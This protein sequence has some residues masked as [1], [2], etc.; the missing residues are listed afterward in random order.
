VTA[1]EIITKVDAQLDNKTLSAFVAKQSDWIIQHQEYFQG[2]QTPATI[3]VDG[4]DLP[5][6]LS[7]HPTDRPWTWEDF[8][9]NNVKL[10]V[11]ACSVRIDFH[12]GPD[13]VGFTIYETFKTL[14]GHFWIKAIGNGPGSQTFDWTEFLPKPF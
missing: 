14:D 5:L 8:L 3:P 1:Q 6:D 4:V 13:G 10:T 12:D 11:L 2:I 9:P 7:V